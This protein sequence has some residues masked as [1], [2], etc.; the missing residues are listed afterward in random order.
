MGQYLQMGICYQMEVDK[1]RLEKLEIT[2][3]RLIKELNKDF[4]LSL[5]DLNENQDEIIFVI[6]ESVVLEQLQKIMQYQYSMYLQEQWDTDCFESASEMIGRLSSIQEIAEL[7]EEKRFPCFQLN[8]VSKEVRVSHW[9]SLRVKFSMWVF[10]V[11]GKIYMECYDNF[12]R[13]IENNIRESSKKWEIAG[14]FKCYID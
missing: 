1:K 4:D 8:T 2:L 13:Y 7:A 14:A 12:L 3:E 5:Y 9:N 10:F 6:K 11:E